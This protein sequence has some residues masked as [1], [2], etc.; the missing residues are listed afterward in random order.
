M[1]YSF[2]GFTEITGL[3]ND[4]IEKS[5]D[6][7]TKIVKYKDPDGNEQQYTAWDTSHV[8]GGV[9]LL[10]EEMFKKKHLSMVTYQNGYFTSHQ[11]DCNV[12]K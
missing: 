4:N 12:S 11:Y 9:K 2:I 5:Q 10:K 7:N 6:I 8:T 1:F 3:Y